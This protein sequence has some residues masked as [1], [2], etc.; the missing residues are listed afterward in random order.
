VSGTAIV[1]DAVPLATRARTQGAVDLCVALAGAG[2]GLG[3][4]AVVAAT[5]YSTLAV[6]GA[7]VALVIVP[8][9]A[10]AARFQVESRIA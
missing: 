9:V 7:V 2:G 1:T 5:S 4:G 3:S 6:G 10:A 8:V